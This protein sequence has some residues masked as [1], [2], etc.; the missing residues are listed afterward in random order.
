M[1]F[2]EKEKW[3]KRKK[4]N[5]KNQTEKGEKDGGKFLKNTRKNGKKNKIRKN[6]EKNE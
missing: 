4:C 2:K 6:N 1:T 5:E 3:K